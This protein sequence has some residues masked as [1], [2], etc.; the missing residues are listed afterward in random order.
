MKHLLLALALV[1]TSAL[2]GV[3]NMVAQCEAVMKCPLCRVANDPKGYP[4]GVPLIVNGRLI[5]ITSDAYNW[6]RNAG[7]GK[8]NGRFVMCARVEEAM[9]DPSSDR[10]IAARYLFNANWIKQDYC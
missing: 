3:E 1:S 9:K 6:I 4:N 10:G 2:A 7:Y 8:A 5:R